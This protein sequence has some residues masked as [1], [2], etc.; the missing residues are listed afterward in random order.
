MPAFYDLLA[1]RLARDGR[2]AVATVIERRGSVPREVGAKMLVSPF[3]E[4]AGTV[5]GGC[6]E[7]LVRRDALDVLR[8]GRPAITRVDLTD[9]ITD[10]SETNCGG[11]ME[12]FVERFALDEGGAGSPTARELLEAL[13]RAR[14]AR[15]PAALATVVAGDPALVGGR[16]LAIGDR[17]RIGGPQPWAG[18]AEAALAEALAS[19]CS[20][21]VALAGPLPVDLFVEALPPAPELVIV[22]AGHIAQPLAAVGK[23]LDFEVTVI[24]DRPDFASRARFPTA[25]RV[26]AD[27]IPAAVARHPIGA[28]SYLVLVTRG[29][30]LDEAVL[31]QVADRPA[32]YIGMIGSR[33]RVTAVFDQLRR[34]GMREEQLA[35][36]HAPIGLDIGA[37][38]PGEIAVAIAAEIV[39]HRRS[40]RGVPLSARLRRPA[41]ALPAR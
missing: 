25:D 30:R 38:T 12:V 1:E 8:T 36:V 24:D 26:V 13:A 21:R 7:A 22:G 35:R 33:R 5:G 3:G 31:R 6:G 9:P 27:D 17:Q 2:V 15:V 16:L 29:H 34:A 19:G 18:A 23:A 20:R 32:E 10:E 41:G 4:I 28:G 11:V 39:N 40:G 14:A 37:D